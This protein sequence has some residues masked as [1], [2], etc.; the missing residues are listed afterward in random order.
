MHHLLST[1]DCLQQAV[2][3]GSE[4]QSARETS[5]LFHVQA[6]SKVRACLFERAVFACS[7]KQLCFYCYGG[8]NANVISARAI[9]TFGLSLEI[10]LDELE[11]GRRLVANLLLCGYKTL[12]AF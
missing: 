2:F 8:T 4:K 10:T 3:A 7:L 5:L 1:A 12:I 6:T 11:V 9:T